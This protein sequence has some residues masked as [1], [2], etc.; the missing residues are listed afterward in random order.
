[1][2]ERLKE[3]RTRGTL[4]FPFELYPTYTLDKRIFVACHWQ[5]E[6]EFIR[7][8]KGKIELYLD[9]IA[10]I[11]STGEIVFINPGQIHQL[12]GLTD[13]TMYYAYVFPMAAL[14]FDQR[15]VTQIQILE[16][17]LDRMIGFPTIITKRDTIYSSVLSIVDAVIDLNLHRYYLYELNTKIHLLELICLL[18]KENRFIPYFLPKQTDICKKILTYIQKHFAEKLI[19]SDIAAEVGL[20]ENYFS[21][22]F[23][24]HFRMGF[25][26]YLTAY[27]IEHACTLLE[28][29]DVSITEIAMCVG[30][31][32]VSYFIQ[33]FKSLKGIT[34]NK[35]RNQN[36]NIVDN[37]RT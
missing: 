27:R 25:V 21:S 34:P 31:D 4:R 10:Y 12:K 16:P 18:K 17:I 26:N 11:V 35:Y 1:M 36:F 3:S 15:D 7:V 22:F 33:K 23:T 37:D 24:E 20:S 32:S 2:N 8:M 13:D 28:T 6:L 14:S 5:D 29:T 19:I 9:G 30:F